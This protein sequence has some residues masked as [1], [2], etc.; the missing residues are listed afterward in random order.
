MIEHFKNDLP[1]TQEE[2]GVW[3]NT[4]QVELRGRTDVPL[5]SYQWTC[6]VADTCFTLV[7][8]WMLTN[9][10]LLQFLRDSTRD[11]VLDAKRAEEE[12]PCPNYEENE[13]DDCTGFCAYVF[14]RDSVGDLGIPNGTYE[15]EWWECDE[16]GMIKFETPSCPDMKYPDQH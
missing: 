12:G 11:Y 15:E 10:T 6:P 3:W 13:D 8:E 2:F 5:N 7:P 14:H 9:D 4:L 16:C 1:S